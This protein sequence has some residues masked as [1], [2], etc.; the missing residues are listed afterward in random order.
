MRLK[1]SLSIIWLI[2]AMLALA[3]VASAQ[4][5]APYQPTGTPTNVTLNSSLPSPQMVG[6]TVTWTISARDTL[7]LEYQFTVQYGSS[8]SPTVIQDYSPSKTMTW[9]PIAEGTYYVGA[10]AREIG[11]TTG[12]TVTSAAYSITTRITAGVPVVTATAHPLVALYSI[13]PC[14]SGSKV[15][16]QFWRASQS[17]P[18]YTFTPNQAC[19]A[20]KS[21]NFYLVGMQAAQIYSIQYVITTNGVST[22]GP[23]PPSPFATGAIPSTVVIPQISEPVPSN[24]FTAVQD[25]VVFHDIVGGASST[26]HMFATNLHGKVL[27]YFNNS[28]SSN[29]QYVD[30]PLANGNTL[31]LLGDNQ[32]NG[33]V[34]GLFDPAGNPLQVTNVGRINEQLAALQTPAPAPGTSCS[35]TSAG[36]TVCTITQLHHEVNTLPNGH[37][38]VIGYVEQVY[39]AGTQASTT[40]LPV[41][42]LSDEIID[43]DKNLQVAWTWT[44]YDGLNINRPA[45]LGETCA[46]GQTEC[47]TTLQYASQSGGTANDWTHADAIVYSS[48]DKNLLVSLRNQDWIV[49]LNYNNAKGN[50]AV[51]WRLGNQGDFSLANPPANDPFPWFSHQFG[52]ENV[53]SNDP[54]VTFD[55]GNT[56][57]A[58]AAAGTCDSRG[59]AYTLDETAMTATLQQNVDLGV[60][61]P[62]DGWAQTLANGNYAW[63]AGDPTAGGSANGLHL[64]FSP[65]G[66]EEFAMQDSG[67]ALYRTYRMGSMYS[68]CCGD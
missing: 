13:P 26:A 43:L 47:P 6:T 45:V 3:P 66:T 52:I 64:E 63:T 27:W 58:G 49:K 12:V 32:G 19:S 29:P 51:L 46:A 38:I 59:Q 4:G 2:A 14:G 54:I 16:I 11:A 53:G 62:T 55:N 61:S 56:R 68:G 57:C 35:F 42:V 41:D 5:W 30:R 24:S 21:S 37:T 15:K 1:G 39:P 33:Q 65:T 67:V 34:L 17:P 36:K 28:L 20:T 25:S 18:Q 8:S 9:V 22:V 31:A 50:G 7:P 48:A 10:T 40:G 44:A 60:Y 23:N